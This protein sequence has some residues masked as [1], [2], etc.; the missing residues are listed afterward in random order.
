MTTLETERPADYLTR[1]A[2]SDFGLAY[3]R[4]VVR[5]MGI[6]TG[7]K[8][9]DLGCGPGAD[10]EA[11]AVAV[12]DAGEVL[13]VDVDEASVD[14]AATTVADLPHVSVMV[15]DAHRVPV[16]DSSFDRVHT[17]RVL[18]HVE[19]P[20]AVVAEVARVLRP[21]GV[22][23]FAEPDWDTLVVD[24]P[25]PAVLAGYRRFV[26]EHAVRYADVGRRLPALCYVS[27]LRV[28]RVVP[29]TAVFRDV[30]EADRVLGFERVTTRAVE[31]GYLTPDQARG[32]LDH[33]REQ[34]FF[35]SVSQF[36]TIAE[37]LPR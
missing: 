32:W 17:D 5:E 27:S 21:G 29:I 18:Q 15:A 34:P 33:L 23:A 6:R 25:D 11:F 24:H 22:V 7:D 35:A 36:V 1:L 8:V 26:T 9:L 10:L 28:V 12:A 20:A 3:K 37:R 4:L 2:V 19:S 31:A 16:A 14:A 30:G 13:G